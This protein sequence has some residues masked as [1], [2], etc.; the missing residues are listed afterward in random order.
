MYN[1]IARD[2]Y[3]ETYYIKGKHPRKALLALFYRQ[4][5]DKIYRDTLIGSQ[6][7]GWVIAGHWLTVYKLLPLKA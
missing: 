6:H 2:Q 7:V 4:H 1:Y 5:A 3:N